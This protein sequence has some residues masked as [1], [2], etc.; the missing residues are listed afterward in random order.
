LHPSDVAA[1]TLE[2]E[3]ILALAGDQGA[4]SLAEVA[5]VK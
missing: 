2:H 1:R 5:V 3:V 4:H